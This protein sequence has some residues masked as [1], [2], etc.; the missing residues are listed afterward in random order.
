MSY[1]RIQR[2]FYNFDFIEISVSRYRSAKQCLS[3]LII[4]FLFSSKDKAT[5]LH[6]NI[7]A[8]LKKE[9]DMI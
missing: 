7:S 2:S 1:K 5:C 3:L 6:L 8:H 9:N 4:S